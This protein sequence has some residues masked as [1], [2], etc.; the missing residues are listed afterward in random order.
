MPRSKKEPPKFLQRNLSKTKNKL[1]R[2]EFAVWAPLAEIEFGDQL[3]AG[4][5]CILH[6]T[7]HLAKKDR[8]F[9]GLEIS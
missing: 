5:E 7:Q 9:R 2:K 6:F 4:E 1:V 3:S 8:D